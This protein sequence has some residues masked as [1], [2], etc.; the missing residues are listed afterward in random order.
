VSKKKWILCTIFLGLLVGASLLV[1]LVRHY[2]RQDDATHLV[3]PPLSVISDDFI[4]PEKFDD[5]PEFKE[6]QTY[7]K[8]LNKRDLTDDEKSRIVDIATKTQHPLTLLKCAAFFKDMDFSPQSERIL[9]LSIA[10]LKNPSPAGRSA[11]LAILGHY[12]TKDHA[13]YVLPYLEAKDSME[14]S[15]ARGVLRKWGVQVPEMPGKE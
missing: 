10:A 7:A 3:P 4:D 6:V 9:K 2:G 15:I 5:V 12:G 8:I 11:G 13:N 1:G 14:Q